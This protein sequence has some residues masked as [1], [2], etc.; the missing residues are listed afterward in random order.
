[1]IGR[2]GLRDRDYQQQAVVTAEPG[3]VLPTVGALVAGPTVG[4]AWWLFM[5]IFRKPLQGIGRASYCVTG[6]WDDP[7]VERLTGDGVDE[8]E[9]CAALPPGGFTAATDQN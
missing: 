7:Q 1:V 4:A 8:V 9:R 2:T 5:R 3:N 6:T